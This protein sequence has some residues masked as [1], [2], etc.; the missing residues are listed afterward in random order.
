M[1]LP[2]KLLS[3]LLDIADELYDPSIK[4]NVKSFGE[5]VTALTRS[6]IH[7][8]IFELVRLYKKDNESDHLNIL[9]ARIQ[10]QIRIH[11]AKVGNARVGN[12]RKRSAL[13]L[14]AVCACTSVAGYLTGESVF[15]TTSSRRSAPC[16]VQW[17]PC[18]ACG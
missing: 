15:D 4:M 5:L 16:C 3:M 17:A 12:A 1:K 11:G 2:K 10:L 6:K 18:V 9:K 7:K 13:S 14:L 8:N